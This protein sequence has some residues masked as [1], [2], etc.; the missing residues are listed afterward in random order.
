MEYF[1]PLDRVWGTC[2]GVLSVSQNNVVDLNDV[3]KI[4]GMFTH[5][6]RGIC[7]IYPELIKENR[8][9]STCNRLDLG[10]LG[11]RPVLVKKS[12]WTLLLTC[13]ERELLY[14]SVPIIHPT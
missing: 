9:M 7:G 10:A 2:C 5:R 1:P 4:L 6:F 14:M 8:K 12:P 13:A 3:M 11:C